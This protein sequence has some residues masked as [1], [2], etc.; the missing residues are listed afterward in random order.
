[1]TPGTL[2]LL[3]NSLGGPVA[4]ILPPQ[5]AEAVRQ[6]DGLIAE[7]DRGG[8]RFLEQF[9]GLKKSPHQV[10]IALLNEH[11]KGRGA[12]QIEH[13]DWLLEPILKGETWGYVSDAGLPCLADPGSALVTR[14]RQKGVRVKVLSGPSAPLLA[15]LA[16][17]LPA[18]EFQF[19]GYA[20]KEPEARKD[21]IRQAAQHG[22]TQICIEAPYRNNAM[23]EALIQHLP[24]ES[25]L[26]L[27]C[28]ASLPSE[29]V[30]V[31]TV[32]QWRLRQEQ[33]R[34]P[35]DLTSRPAVFLFLP[36]GSLAGGSDASMVA[37]RPKRSS[38]RSPSHE[39]SR[40]AHKPPRP[41][42]E[43]ARPRRSHS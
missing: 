37:S 12:A 31:T 34:M 17:G 33:Q 16:S 4:E 32:S 2:Y 10:P 11:S 22:V 43:R 28:D 14:A 39:R 29:E 15:L 35:S 38:E 20:P 5:V 42:P 27:V 25:L 23:L 3:P 8:R 21:W 26:A 7:S 19:H 18:Q 9:Q 1:M 30:L 13:L 24:E 41:S 6:L 36:R 40:T